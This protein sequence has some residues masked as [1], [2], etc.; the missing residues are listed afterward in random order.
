[1]LCRFIWI[2]F[3]FDFFLS[4]SRFL[5]ILVGEGGGEAGGGGGD[6]LYMDYG[7]L[8]ASSSGL[9]KSMSMLCNSP[10]PKSVSIID[11]QYA[12]TNLVTCDTYA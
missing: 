9:N 4:F 8:F 7:V 3:F 10:P 2:F 6:T 11:T 5:D 1:M 12:L